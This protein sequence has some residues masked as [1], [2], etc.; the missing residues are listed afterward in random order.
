M[1]LNDLCAYTAAYIFKPDY[2]ELIGYALLINA[3]GKYLYMTVS[4]IV[5]STVFVVGRFW[6]NQ[7]R[8]SLETG[9]LLNRLFHELPST[10]RLFSCNTK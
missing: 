4:L 3:H 6:S 9:K 5:M 10:R 2:A 7:L 1:G 8:K